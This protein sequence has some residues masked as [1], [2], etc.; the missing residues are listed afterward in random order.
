VI[1]SAEFLGAH[2]FN[3]AKG[4]DILPDRPN[5]ADFDMTRQ[6]AFQLI[7][8]LRMKDPSDLVLGSSTM[9]MKLLDQIEAYPFIIITQLPTRNGQECSMCLT[10]ETQCPSGAFNATL[11]EADPNKCILCMRCITTCPDNILQINE[12]TEA[13]HK[14]RKRQKLTDDVL[15]QR[16]SK[17]F[18]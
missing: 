7:E 2:S 4:W 3:C 8:K 11:G 6:Y 16:E 17:F 5:Q 14:L 1:A 15:S 18:M 12:L 9:T 13:C 10:C